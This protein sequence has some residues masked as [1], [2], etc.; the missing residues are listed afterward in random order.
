MPDPLILQ[1]PGGTLRELFEAVGCPDGLTLEPATV[2][3]SHHLPPDAR[4][5]HALETAHD[6]LVDRLTHTLHILQEI[7]QIRSEEGEVSPK[8]A[9]RAMELL[10]R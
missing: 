3:F 4:Y 10:E 8:M 2:P 1:I 6:Q 5:I 9:Q 7:V